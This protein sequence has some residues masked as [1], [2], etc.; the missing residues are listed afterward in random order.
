MRKS[1]LE[2][3]LQ[4]KS[5]KSILLVSHGRVDLKLSFL[6]SIGGGE[7]FDRVIEETFVLTERACVAFMKQIIEGVSYMHHH[8]IIHLDLKVGNVRCANSTNGPFSPLDNISRDFLISSLSP[9]QCCRFL[10][11]YIL[12]HLSSPYLG[13]DKRPQYSS[14]YPAGR[15]TAFESIDIGECIECIYGIKA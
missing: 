4:D 10:S 6:C 9:I 7:L 15:R 11:P 2:L 12:Y 5:E 8:Q 1:L 3:C 14:Q 13:K